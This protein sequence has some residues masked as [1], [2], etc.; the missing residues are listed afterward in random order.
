VCRD[1]QRDREKGRQTGT[2]ELKQIEKNLFN[3][4]ERLIKD[5]GALKT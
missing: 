3:C 1:R 2:E 4:V 5:R